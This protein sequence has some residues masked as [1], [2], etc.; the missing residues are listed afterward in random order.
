ML[1][2]TCLAEKG[3]ERVVSSTNGFVCGHLS[4]WLDTMLETVQLPTSIADL[5]TSLSNMYR[6]TLTLQGKEEYKTVN[7][8]TK[9]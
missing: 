3:V 9:I 6:D 4:V 5:H 7:L 8:V 1:S 2:C